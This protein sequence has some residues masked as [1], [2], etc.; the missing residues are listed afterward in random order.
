[1]SEKILKIKKVFVWTIYNSLKNT[2]PKDFPTTGE[3]KETIS[4]V[5]PA[6]KQHVPEYLNLLKKVE[7]V[8]EQFTEKKIK[9]DERDKKLND[10]NDEFRVYNKDH[11]GD[12]CELNLSE[13]GFKTLKTQFD[14]DN[15]GKKW[16]VNIEEFGELMQAFE[17]AA[18]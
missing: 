10:I 7:E 6:L 8:H 14:R 5:M 17:E 3:I 15:W 13:E 1:M 4:S 2:P 18:K 9:E 16:V 11:S 12:L